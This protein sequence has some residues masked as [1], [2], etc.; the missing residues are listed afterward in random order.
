MVSHAVA[1]AGAAAFAGAG[2]NG[3]GLVG[4]LLG[5]GVG[6]PLGIAVAYLVYLRLFAPRRRLQ[7]SPSI[8][9]FLLDPSR[10]VLI[11]AI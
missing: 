3:M 9:S 7:V 10:P 11:L 2:G 8:A 5:F 1:A 4:G 6:L